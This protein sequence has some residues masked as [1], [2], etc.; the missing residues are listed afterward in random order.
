[1]GAIVKN[2]NIVYSGSQTLYL[3]NLF[4]YL[5]LPYVK[6]IGL[7]SYANNLGTTNPKVVMPIMWVM[8]LKNWFLFIF[9]L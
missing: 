4:F 9:T 7:S 2:D 3:Y 6:N 5:F 1:M 8:K